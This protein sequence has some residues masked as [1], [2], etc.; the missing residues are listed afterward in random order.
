MSTLG[1]HWKVKDISKLKGNVN[2]KGKKWKDTSNHKGSLGK[3]WKIKDTSRMSECRKGKKKTE[4]TKRNMKKASLKRWQD[5]NYRK[6]LSN[7][8]KGKKS[9]NW[10][11]GKSFEPYGLEFNEDLK[12]VIR[13]R[14]RRKCFICEKTELELGYKLS[15]HHIDYNKQNNNPNNLVSLCRNC[16]SKTN[17]RRENW[18]NYFN[19]KI[20]Q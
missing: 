18:T 14:D 7:A 15:I 9:Y 16:H 20:C 19:A 3:H 2:A 1:K 17:Y 6:K 12:E 8:Q 5:P 13:N 10:Q 11:G 4:E